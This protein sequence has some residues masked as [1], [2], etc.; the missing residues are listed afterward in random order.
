MKPKRRFIWGDRRWSDPV[1]SALIGID[2]GTSSVRAIAF[3]ER[4]R[5]LAAASRPTPTKIVETGGEFDPDAIFATV[6]A[7]LAEVAQGL[8]GRPVAGI[9]VASVGESCVLI[10]AAGRSLA[11]SI[12]W[13]DR[14]T[15]AA[16]ALHR[17]DHRAR[18]DLR[19]HRPLGRA[20]LHA[21]KASLDARALAG[22][23]SQRAARADDGGLDRLPAVG[24]SGDRSD[25]RL[26]HAL[27]RHPAHRWS[28][29]LLALAGLALG[30]SRA[31]RGVR[32]RRSGRCG[33][34]CWRRRDLPARRSSR[35]A[36]TITS[37][38]RSRPG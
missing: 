22:R 30:F 11:P 32:A 13:H 28:E 21:R 36:G 35:S 23:V 24:R 37:S 34:T 25:A 3:D 16:G 9:A 2:V 20:D 6:L 8:A 18:T 26:A 10:D 15:E 38:A 4:G 27:F 31:A 33:A 14:R 29:E 12:V 17:D 7:A 19:D 5:R 1:R